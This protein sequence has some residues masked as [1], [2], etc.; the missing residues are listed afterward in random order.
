MEIPGDVGCGRGAL[1][2][3]ARRAV[4]GTCAAGLAARGQVAAALGPGVG[5][6]G[7]LFELQS[8]CLLE[9][10]LTP[11]L[12]EATLP[13]VIEQA[14]SVLHEKLTFGALVF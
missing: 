3:A 13:I 9:Q 5:D 7:F 6:D 8:E 4:R 2:T 1:A 12:L 11:E 10:G 14:S